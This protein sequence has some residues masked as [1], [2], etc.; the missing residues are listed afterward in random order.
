M[1]WEFKIKQCNWVI[2][3]RIMTVARKTWETYK[4]Y[5]ADTSL[6]TANN[7]SLVSDSIYTPGVQTRNGGRRNGRR[8]VVDGEQNEVNLPSSNHLLGGR[9]RHV[10]VRRNVATCHG[11]CD[12]SF[13]ETGR[14]SRT[15]GWTRGGLWFPVSPGLLVCSTRMS[16]Y[17]VGCGGL[18]ELIMDIQ[19]QWTQ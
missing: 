11:R 2:G 9:G 10:Q 18:L 19:T 7:K 6:G 12:R 13:R 4:R 16:T 5:V 15:C 1:G 3:N 14:A 8:P 17:P